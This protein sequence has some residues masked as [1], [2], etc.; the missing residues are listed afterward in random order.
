MLRG[1]DVGFAINISR[2]IGTINAEAPPGDFALI[3]PEGS[4]TTLGRSIVP[5]L[6]RRILVELELVVILRRELRRVGNEL[7]LFL[8]FLRRPARS[9]LLP[10]RWVPSTTGF[11]DPFNMSSWCGE[12][13]AETTFISLPQDA[14]KL[15]SSN[16]TLAINLA[17]FLRL[18]LTNWLSSSS[19]TTTSFG[20]C[21]V[22]SFF[23]HPSCRR[24]VVEMAP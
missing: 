12:E 11:Q 2:Q 4:K 15:G 19:T 24:M 17:Q 21:G 23:I 8:D 10:P 1:R 22:P 16:H 6:R 3:V 13:R 9:A 5:P 14:H 7:E 18:T 20:A